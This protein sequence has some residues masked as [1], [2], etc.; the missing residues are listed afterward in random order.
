VLLSVPGRRDG[1]DRELAVATVPDG[2]ITRL[3]I[4]GRAPQY[5][6]GMVAYV[7]AG[8]ALGA[9]PFDPVAR[10]ATGEA[11]EAIPGSVAWILAP[12]GTLV[13]YENAGTFRLARV[14]R[15]GKE[16][17]LLDRDAL[18]SSPALS[19]DGRRVALSI[20][21]PPAGTEIWVAELESRTVTRLSA[22]LGGVTPTWS[23]DGRRVLWSRRGDRAAVLAQP[24]D[25]SAPPEVLVPGGQGNDLLPGGTAMLTTFWPP[26]GRPEHRIVPLPYDSA[27]RSSPIVLRR[28]PGFAMARLSPDGQWIAFV[29]EQNGVQEVFVHSRATGG[30]YQVSAGGGFEPLWRRDGRELFYRTRTGLMAARLALGAEARVVGRDSLFAAGWPPGV[31]WPNY[32]VTADGNAFLIPLPNVVADWPTVTLGWTDELRERLREGGGAGA[33]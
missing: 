4:A 15:T 17:R 3:G 20:G 32:D 22:E 21:M 27:H 29:D 18:Y 33:R 23:A 12:N 9:L 28:A 11:T 1:A 5:A 10:R 8:G 25:A 6:D 26:S 24:W 19:P 30:R 31:V 2:R 16:R 7:R 13:Q 14:D